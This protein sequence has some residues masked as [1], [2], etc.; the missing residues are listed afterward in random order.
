LRYKGR[1]SGQEFSTPVAYFEFGDVV[2]IALTETANRS[3]W[4][5]FREPWPLE[6]RI[7]GKW[8]SG[9]AKV[10]P[11]GSDDYRHWFEKVLSVGPYMPWIFGV[12]FGRRKGLTPDQAEHLAGR[13][14]LVLFAASVG[15]LP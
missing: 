13:S 3:W 12:K 11:P 10:L 8:R 2:A 4:R 7:K 1:K 15:R 6:L 5:N 14:G 9:Y